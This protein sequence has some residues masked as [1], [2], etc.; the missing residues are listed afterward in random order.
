[1]VIP[2]FV[3]HYHPAED[4]PFR[5]L[6][7]APADELPAI[8]ERLGRRRATGF[9]RVFGR[10]YMDFRRKTEAKLKALFEQAGGRPERE[11]PHYFILGESHWFAGLYPR[12][13]HVRLPLAALPPATS[14]FTYPDSFV[15]MRLGPEFGLPPD[16]PRPYHERVFHMHE[17]QG[18]VKAYGLPHDETGDDAYSD[19]HLRDFERYVEIQVWSDETV[20]AFLRDRV[21]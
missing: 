20:R 19:Y 7:D 8:L 14:S 21:N 16:P 2:N 18:I 5:N 6:C 10:R 3:T 15:S 11:S 17:L 4:A 13:N 1:M 9:K 12:P